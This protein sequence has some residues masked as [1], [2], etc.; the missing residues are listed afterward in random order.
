MRAKY[1]QDFH[2]GL[3]ALGQSGDAERLR[4]ALI[5]ASEAVFDWSIADDRIQWDGAPSVLS[6]HPAPQRLNSGQALRAWLSPQ[7]RGRLLEFIDE[8]SPDDPGFTMEF[9]VVSALGTEWFELCAVRLP[10]ADGRTERVT[11]IL[12]VITDRKTT[13][14][15]LTYLA[16]YDEMTGHLNRTRLRE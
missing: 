5:S 10:G 13:Q 9:D 11:G 7:V 14:S 6:Y 4:L 8:P 2:D 16:T 15:H 12:R 3:R 1:Q